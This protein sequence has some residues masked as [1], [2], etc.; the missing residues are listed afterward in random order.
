MSVSELVMT[1][2]EKGAIPRAELH[3]FAIGM[4]TLP[5]RLIKMMPVI[6][7]WLAPSS[8]QNHNVVLGNKNALL[9]ISTADKIPNPEEE[10]R[11]KG[12][13]QEDAKNRGMNIEF[14]Q[15]S[16]DRYEKRVVFLI[17]SLYK[18]APATTKW[19]IIQ[20]DDTFWTTQEALLDFVRKYPD[21]LTNSLF[22]G[23]LSEVQ[24]QIVGFGQI[25]FG[26]GGILLSRHLMEIM[27]R[28]GALEE[29]YD[30]FQ[31]VFGGDGIITK[32]IDYVAKVSPIFD[33][34]LHQLDFR[35]N[36][37][38]SANAVGF[39]L[40]GEPVAT[41]HHWNE[42]LTIFPETHDMYHA[43]GVASIMLIARVCKAIGSINFGR[44][45]SMDNGK[46]VVTLG[47]SVV[48]YKTP[49]TAEEL[50]MVEVTM[51]EMWRP[52]RPVRG[53]LQE[54]V[55]KVSYYIDYVTELPFHT[56]KVVRM[57]YRN[58]KMEYLFVDWIIQ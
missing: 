33:E 40:L 38:N 43:N 11:L 52:I 29:C 19:F 30:K 10:T 5:S 12:L 48:V 51:N 1:D 26:G 42:W 36:T 44:R 23:A 27:N 32:C 21:P 13:I 35:K 34:R 37:K 31:S 45:F 54:G 25:A 20:D 46:V 8:R 57:A 14:Q 58:A 22:I 2:E 50:E 9:L 7:H 4:A 16:I 28:D 56:R 18:T 55:D 24:A 3:D 49:I 17:A 15:V 6:S 41:L 53:Y 39:F 47:Y